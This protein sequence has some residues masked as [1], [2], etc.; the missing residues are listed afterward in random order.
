MMIFK[1]TAAGDLAWET[2]VG[3]LGKPPA[4]D[5]SGHFYSARIWP[6]HRFDKGFDA[7]KYDILT[8][9]EIWARKYTLDQDEIEERKRIVAVHNLAVDSTGSFYVGLHMC[10][11][12]DIGN[13][14]GSAGKRILK[15]TPAGELEFEIKS[16]QPLWWIVVD[17]LDHLYT[18]SSPSTGRIIT[19]KYVQAPSLPRFRRGDANGDGDLD[20]SDAINSLHFQFLGSSVNC[21]DAADLDDSGETEVTDV[22][23]L[24]NYLFLEGP[25][26]VS[27][28]PDCGADVAED[29][30]PPCEY[31]QESCEK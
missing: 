4:L 21:V 13:P 12:N 9:D 29:D 14:I 17:Q 30:F 2:T 3:R 22:I 8:G 31:P 28:F 7:C 11:V 16:P 18:L 19:T 5:D 26:P 15:Y 27:P 20:I 6:T 1:Y 10:F 23:Y 25:P 24:L